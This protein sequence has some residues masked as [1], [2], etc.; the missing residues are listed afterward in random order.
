[1]K[2]AL[3]AIL[4]LV[5]PGCLVA[6]LYGPENPTTKTKASVIDAVVQLSNG[7]TMTR[8]PGNA[9]QA[10]LCTGFGEPREG[11]PITF[12][13]TSFCY[14]TIA[15]TQAIT[16][17][18]SLC[19]G[20]ICSASSCPNDQREA[21]IS[22]T[23]TDERPQMGP[24]PPSSA[25]FGLVSAP[26]QAGGAE[27]ARAPGGGDSWRLETST[28]TAA[29]APCGQAEFAFAPNTAGSPVF[30]RTDPSDA[31]RITLGFDYTNLGGTHP[32]GGEAAAYST[33][34]LVKAVPA[35]SPIQKSEFTLSGRRAIT[36]D[37][38]TLSV[39]GMARGGEPFVQFEVRY[40]DVDPMIVRV[41]LED[42]GTGVAS[43]FSSNGT[44]GVVLRGGNIITRSIDVD[45]DAVSY[46]IRY[47]ALHRAVRQAIGRGLLTA[48]A[49]STFPQSPSE[50]AP[51]PPSFG[52]SGT[53]RGELEVTR[54]SV[55]SSAS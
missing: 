40:L 7:F 33:T 18:S 17:T 41:L 27:L 14:E 36:L 46:A 6:T 42:T 21:F 24:N 47:R 38:G 1:M 51:G 26:L 53:T 34:A 22:L 10:Y 44:Q 12:T 3:L 19:P 13:G 31:Q 20:P 11:N 8:N 16:Y 2:R 29:G 4:L 5:L 15:S 48:A 9:A 49:W 50:W 54:W 30:L 28:A 37:D 23:F 25:T 55:V 32:C 45:S 52:V 35:A 43:T 39:Y